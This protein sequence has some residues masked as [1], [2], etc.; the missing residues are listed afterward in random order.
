V[1][2]VPDEKDRGDDC[3]REKTS[4]IFDPGRGVLRV[5]GVGTLW[6]LVF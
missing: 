2:N 6:A 3:E 4:H 1:E 5:C